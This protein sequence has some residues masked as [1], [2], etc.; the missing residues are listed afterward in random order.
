MC[1]GKCACHLLGR[2]IRLPC[3]EPATVYGEDR[4]AA[5]ERDDATWGMSRRRFLKGVGVVG[6]GAAIADPDVLSAQDKPAQ[7]LD[8]PPAMA[9]DGPRRITLTV[10]GRGVHLMVELR[11][12]LLRALR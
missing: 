2:D 4:M 8:E 7:A 5:D 6:A 10:N 1:V 11:V 12:A 3:F 9:A